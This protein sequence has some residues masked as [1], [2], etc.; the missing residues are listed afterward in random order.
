MTTFV[1]SGHAENTACICHTKHAGQHYL[2]GADLLLASLVE[3]AEVSRA[4]GIR[5][6]AVKEASAAGIRTATRSERGYTCTFLEVLPIEAS[7]T[8]LGH[9]N[10]LRSLF[11]LLMLPRF[12]VD[13]TSR[14]E[15]C[16][17]R[18]LAQKS[19]MC[20]GAFPTW[21]PSCAQP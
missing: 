9:G 2:L 4:A 13:L 12:K 10:A 11:L 21:Q 6:A 3:T 19:S 7:T 20:D 8:T 16:L 14:S 15:M 5:S 1:Y 18:H 17:H